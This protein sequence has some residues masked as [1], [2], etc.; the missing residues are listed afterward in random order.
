MLILYRMDLEDKSGMF[1]AMSKELKLILGG[2]PGQAN[3]KIGRSESGDAIKVEPMRSDEDVFI[4]CNGNRYYRDGFRGQDRGR[5]GGYGREDRI[6]PYDRHS[7][8][9]ENR[10]DDKGQVTRCRYCDSKYHYQYNCPHYHKRQE[11]DDDDRQNGDTKSAYVIE[12]I[13]YALAT[14]FKDGFGNFTRTARTCAALDTCCT[15]S[16]A[17]RKWLDMYIQQL[18]EE[19][20]KRVAGPDFSKKLFKFGNNGMLKV[21]CARSYSW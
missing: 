16:V 10:K 21:L 4:T 17:G 14:Q 9:R 15:S 7:Q 5:G 19:E 1:E 3:V 12:E 18:C 2:G 20:R 8:P 6:K 13:D 11:G